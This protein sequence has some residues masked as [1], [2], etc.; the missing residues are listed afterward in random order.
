M[1][2][3]SLL[4]DSFKLSLS[5]VF[6]S[7]GLAPIVSSTD[8]V[9][10]Y[11]LYRGPHTPSKLQK[12][13]GLQEDEALWEERD[14]NSIGGIVLGVEMRGDAGEE[15][16]Y[17]AMVDPPPALPHAAIEILDSDDESEDDERI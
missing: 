8:P 5:R 16:D 2:E 14:K 1:R 3:R 10:T 7:V 9:G 17:E 6:Q 4:N 11:A 15:Y 12:R 13:F